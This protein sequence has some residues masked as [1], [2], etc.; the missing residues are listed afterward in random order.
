MMDKDVPAVPLA[1]NT[2]CLAVGNDRFFYSLGGDT[3]FDRPQQN[4]EALPSTESGSESERS[5]ISP[6]D[7]GAA[8]PD[9]ANDP[10]DGG[11]P[12]TELTDELARWRERA[13]EDVTAWR[14]HGAGSLSVGS[15]L[16]GFTTTII[17]EQTHQWI[18][19]YLAGCENVEDVRWAFEQ[20]LSHEA[21]QTSEPTPEKHVE[22]YAAPT[23]KIVLQKRVHEL[24]SSVAER[25]HKTLGEEST[26]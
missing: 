24:F 17:P 2:L 20:V 1:L 7:T 25:G 18:S 14:E 22:E 3:H 21:S 26:E 10:A 19:K 15:T 13:I 8:T 11:E 12:S 9:P 5:N 16:R 23:D 6:G 4:T